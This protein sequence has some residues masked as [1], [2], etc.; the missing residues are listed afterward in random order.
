MI[1]PNPPQAEILALDPKRYLLGEGTGVGK[2]YNRLTLVTEPQSLVSKSGRKR[3]FVSAVCECGVVK[4]Y[5]LQHLISGATNSC[6]CYNRELQKERH[7]T[8]GMYGTRPYKIWSN[9]K[10]RC[11]NIS[12]FQYKDYGGRGI[13]VCKK[14]EKFQGFYEDMKAGYSDSLTLDRI[15][16]DKGYSVS[17][18]RWVTM[19]EQ[20]RNRRS[21]T[22]WKFRGETKTIAQWAEELGINYG[23]LISRVT[24]SNWSI[25]KALTTPVR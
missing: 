23:T 3:L 6:G 4:D 24:R 21:N 11:S 7:T 10:N 16:N 17:N 15:N 19:K 20:Q 9:M 13:R 25:K 1:T 5:R 8:H 14:W 18:C 12:Y 22:F 2:T